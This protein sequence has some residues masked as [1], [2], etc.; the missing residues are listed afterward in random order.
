PDVGLPVGLSDS[1][2]IANVLLTEFDTLVRDELSPI[3]Y[4]RY[5]DDIFL[6]LRSRRAFKSG[7]EVLRWLAKRLEPQLTFDAS[8]RKMGPRLILQLPYAGESRLVFAGNKLKIFPLQGQQ[9]LD[10]VDQLSG[11]ITKQSSERRMLPDL[12]DD[13]AA[14][15]NNALLAT[16]EESLDADA[17]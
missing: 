11:Q 16:P 8:D 12:P 13:E 6:V 9:G 15:A 17:L 3:Y 14:I 5:V 2:I 4:G 1:K 10:L 7:E